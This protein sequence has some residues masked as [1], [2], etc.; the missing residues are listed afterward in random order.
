MITGCI[1]TY[2]TA[3]LAITASHCTTTPLLA[4]GDVAIVEVDKREHEPVSIS[5][6]QLRGR[7]TMKT[8]EEVPVTILMPVIFEPEGYDI[9]GKG[10]LIKEFIRPG[11]SGSPVF[12]NKGE[13]VAIAHGYYGLNGVVTGICQ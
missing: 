4:W 13:L 6:E 5:C 7:Y 9:R 10:Y 3:T 1:I 11:L 2:I 8:P 12:N